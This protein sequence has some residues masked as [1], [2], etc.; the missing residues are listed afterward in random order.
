MPNLRHSFISAKSDSAD[1]SIVRPTN[2]NAKL[3]YTSADGA[4]SGT[5]AIV[6]EVLT[7]ARTYYVRTDGNDSN[8]GLADTSTGAFLTIAGAYAALCLSIDFGGQTVTLTLGDGTT[9]TEQ[10]SLPGPWS[11]GGEFVFD[12]NGKTLS[13]TG[14]ADAT[15]SVVYIACTLPGRFTVQNVT[16]Q[17]AGTAGSAIWHTG[18]GTVDVGASVIFSTVPVAGNA[19]HM[20]AQGTGAYIE[21]QDNYTV[22]GSAYNH[23]C[24]LAGGNIGL[25]F[26]TVTL[27]TTPSWSN[28]AASALDAGIVNS[29]G[30]TFSGT[31]SGVRYT[32]IMNGV[33]DTFGSGANYFPGNQAGTTAT[34]G[35]Y[36]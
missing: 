13:V 23:V 5:D 11:G 25:Y 27:N 14:A 18:V 34:G 22:S 20:L 16:L 12:G 3:Q 26:N 28:A 8:T 36:G 17:A 1:S 9:W 32:V 19:R 24:A 10:V 2:W 4:P 6:R 33:V 30:T 35:Q 7:A 21:S 15:G 31:S 29:F